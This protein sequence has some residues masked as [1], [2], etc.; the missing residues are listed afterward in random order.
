MQQLQRVSKE[1]ARK[2]RVPE[3]ENVA[4]YVSALL[5]PAGNTA[6]SGTNVSISVPKEGQIS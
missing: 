4:E 2:R 1:A 3:N 6:R 5:H